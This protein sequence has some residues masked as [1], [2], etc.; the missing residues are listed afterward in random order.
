MEELFTS[1]SSHPVPRLSCLFMSDLVCVL[2]QWSFALLKLAQ[3]SNLQI[4]E[5]GPGSVPYPMWCLPGF[6]IVLISQPLSILAFCVHLEVVKSTNLMDHFR[7]EN[8]PQPRDYEV[9]VSSLS[10]EDI[11]CSLKHIYD[12]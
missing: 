2:L 10:I 7:P 9:F 12:E 6:D 3:A 5:S 8:I 11:A 4:Y 1:L